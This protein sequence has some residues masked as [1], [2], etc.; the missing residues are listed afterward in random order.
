MTATVIPRI[1]RQRQRTSSEHLTVSRF[2]A[3]H[4]YVTITTVDQQGQLHTLPA[5]VRQDRFDGEIHFELDPAEPFL[6]RIRSRS[7]VTVTAM[8]PAGR[9]CLTLH[10]MARLTRRMP[11][12]RLWKLDGEPEPVT[13]TFIVCSADLWD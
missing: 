9:R 6:D 8:D 4:P 12:L 10:G 11:V 5:L 7:A 1:E 3:A 2:L 13:L